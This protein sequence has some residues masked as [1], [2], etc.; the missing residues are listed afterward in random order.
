MNK[1]K[2]LLIQFPSFPSLFCS[3]S[4]PNAHDH[5]W[6]KGKAQEIF[7]D[8]V[9]KKRTER[10]DQVG[11]GVGKKGKELGQRKGQE[12]KDEAKRWVGERDG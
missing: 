3:Y 7:V 9:N 10:K 5:V 1:F 11:K 8:L 2:S 6:H 12:L 4:I